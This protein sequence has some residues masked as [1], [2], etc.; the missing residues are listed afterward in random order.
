MLAIIMCQ[1]LAAM[2]R[3]LWIC[4]YVLDEGI[5]FTDIIAALLLRH[6]QSRRKRRRGTLK[7]EKI[8][9]LIRNSAY[10]TTRIVLRSY[11]TFIV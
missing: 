6:S 4:T 3:W 9:D 10:E 7:L 5:G 11:V 1:S 8:I 2:L